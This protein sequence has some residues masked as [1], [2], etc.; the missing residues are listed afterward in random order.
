MPEFVEMYNW[1]VLQMKKRIG[2]PPEGVIYPVWAWHT[3]RSKRHKPDLRSERWANGYDG[4]KFV[5][6]EIE[7]PDEQVLLSDF[8]LWSLILL[9]S[10][11]TETEE[12]EKTEEREEEKE[13]FD[14]SKKPKPKAAEDDYT[15]ISPLGYIGY[16]LI[17]CIPIVGLVFEILWATSSE[18]VNL[19]NYAR[20]QLIALAIGV[21][22]W[23]IVFFGF[24]GGTL[25]NVRY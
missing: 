20:A 16:N 18:K 25:S 7:V 22:I 14:P 1:L 17:F 21:C 6:L 19:K 10:I 11:I 3:Q 12:E 2:D 4:E 5:C 15:P 23:L 8:D 24:L 13:E 9:D